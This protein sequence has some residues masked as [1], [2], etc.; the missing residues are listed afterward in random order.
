MGKGVKESKGL[1][2]R[3]RWLSLMVLLVVSV[4]F[5]AGGDC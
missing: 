2:R 3:T 1:K 4:V 5:V